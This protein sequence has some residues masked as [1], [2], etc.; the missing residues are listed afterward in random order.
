MPNEVVLVEDGR[1]T[2]E[3]DEVKSINQSKYKK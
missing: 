3:L 1:L 2:K